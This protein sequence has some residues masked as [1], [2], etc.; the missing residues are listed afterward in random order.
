MNTYLGY[1]TVYL[2]SFFIS[3]ELALCEAHFTCEASLLF[4]KGKLALLPIYDLRHA[5]PM[6]TAIRLGPIAHLKAC[7]V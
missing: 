4:P 7:V 3:Y 2:I 6:K 1:F 5:Y